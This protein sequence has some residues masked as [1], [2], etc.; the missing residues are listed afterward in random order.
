MSLPNS[1]ESRAIP[2]LVKFLEDYCNNEAS[3]FTDWKYYGN[4]TQPGDYLK[5]R[6]QYTLD[7]NP[8]SSLSPWVYHFVLTAIISR[9]DMETLRD[10]CADWL[11]FIRDGALQ[12]LKLEGYQDA[13]TFDGKTLTLFEG[14]IPRE[15]AYKLEQFQDSPVYSE[16]T[17]GRGVIIWKFD[18]ADHNGAL[19]VGT[20]LNWFNPTI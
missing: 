8:N 4:S 7:K 3:Q 18:W 15:C 19:R 9:G 13:A 5:G 20:E 10:Q 16:S 12:K 2:A 11:A 1:R 17:G 6:I 14:L